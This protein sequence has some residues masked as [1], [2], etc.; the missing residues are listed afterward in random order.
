M[1]PVAHV[2]EFCPNAECLENRTPQS[3]L[4]THIERYGLTQAGRQRYRCTACGR[5]F[6]ATTGTLFYRRRT[7]AADILETLALI[8]AGHRV[9][10]IARVKGHKE[11]TILHWLRTAAQHV[12][13][14]ETALLANY[15]LKRGQL[16]ARWSYSKR[17]RAKKV[18]PPT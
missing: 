15:Q 5:T 13:M 6:R 10:S 7:S 9:S 16:D 8:A 18:L 1:P 3:I 12:E 4:Q 2:G 17:T 11:D 14:L